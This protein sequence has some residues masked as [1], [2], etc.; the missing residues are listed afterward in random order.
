M[1]IR[2]R[3]PVVRYPRPVR[4]AQGLDDALAP[5]SQ[6]TADQLAELSLIHISEPTR[7]Y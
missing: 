5:F 3:I 4:I 1:C 6:I 2:D 7:P